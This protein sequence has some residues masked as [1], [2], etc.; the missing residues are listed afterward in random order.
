MLPSSKNNAQNFSQCIWTAAVFSWDTHYTYWNTKVDVMSKSA[1]PGFAPHWGFSFYLPPGGITIHIHV[2]SVPPIVLTKKNLSVGVNLNV[3]G[4]LHIIP[5]TW[6]W[7][8]Q[9][10]LVLV[11]VLFWSLETFG[12][13]CWHNLPVIRVAQ[14]T[15]QACYFVLSKKSAFPNCRWWEDVEDCYIK[16]ECY[17]KNWSYVTWKVFLSVAHKG[18]NKMQTV[19]L[20]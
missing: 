2:Q 4:S 20:K 1:A 6:K 8:F 3:L 16:G 5:F 14:C 13:V 11:L 9:T 19:L 7:N 15:R 18:G 10:D 17:V 12:A